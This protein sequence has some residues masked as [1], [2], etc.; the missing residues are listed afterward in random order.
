LPLS[1]LDRLM[2]LEFFATEDTAT[3]SSSPYLI[4][5]PGTDQSAAHPSEYVGKQWIASYGVQTI[6]SFSLKL[7]F[8]ITGVSVL[9]GL[10][11]V[12]QQLR[13]KVNASKKGSLSPLE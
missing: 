11:L 12:V 4:S 3:V 8:R 10:S 9:R 5:Q 13:R 7:V 6:G 1:G 2:R